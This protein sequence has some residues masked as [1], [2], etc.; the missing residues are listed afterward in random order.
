MQLG[1][2][3][4]GVDRRVASGAW[5]RVK[6]AVYR[7]D[8]IP[9][10][11]SIWYQQRCA[12][13]LALLAAG[14]GAIAVGFA[15]LLIHGNTSLPSRFA[16]R[17]VVPGRTYRAAGPARTVSQH[18]AFVVQTV[19]NRRVARVED[20]VVQVLPEIGRY[21]LI[22]LLDS[23][24]RLGQLPSLDLLAKRASRRRGV[25]L[26]RSVLTLV[27]GRSESYLESL[28]RVSCIDGGIPPDDVQVPFREANRVVARGDL[29]WRLPD[30][31][32]LIV[33]VDGASIH[34]TPAAVFAD[35]KRMNRLV[36]GGRIVMLRF[37][38][39]DLR[40]P[41]TMVNE[42]RSALQQLSGEA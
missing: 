16:P 5:Q 41:S 4:S 19:A 22:A 6:P 14:R 28:V 18:R 1:M 35:R 26:L 8:P 37:T 9:I 38:A 39:H 31:R 17:V 27:D 30:G 32:W 25:R 23:A 42:I 36:A 33:E 15:A 12:V 2:S 21:G 20:A 7:V 29:G 13:E 10:D 24:V 11:A 34:D 40:Q 3:S